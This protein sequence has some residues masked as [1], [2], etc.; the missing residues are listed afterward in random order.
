MLQYFVTVASD[1]NI[2]ILQK[3]I[4]NFVIMG[5]K[6]QKVEYSLKELVLL[7]K[8][9]LANNRNAVKRCRANK[10]KAKSC[11]P[12]LRPVRRMSNVCNLI[13]TKL[14]GLVSFNTQ[15]RIEKVKGMFQTVVK[16]PFNGEGPFIIQC[17]H[18]GT[19]I[20]WLEIKRGGVD[21]KGY[22]VFALQDIEKEMLITLYLG[23]VYNNK[24]DYLK[25]SPGDDYTLCSEVSFNTKWVSNKAKR[26]F[27]SPDLKGKK[28]TPGKDEM[29]LAG[30]LINSIDGTGKYSNVAFGEAFQ[31]YSLKQIK[32]GDELLLNYNRQME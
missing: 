30:H 4:T 8:Q 23:E 18:E 26:M 6:I 11:K 27:I 16:Y 31:I 13:S 22:G 32:K 24:K 15:E 21:P 9:Q 1:G 10:K 25:S 17:L 28:W 29:Y 14:D 20:D 12:K 19:F 2:V 5:R 3:F 7:R